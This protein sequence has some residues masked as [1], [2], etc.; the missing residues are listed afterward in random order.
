MAKAYLTTGPALSIRGTA[1]LWDGFGHTGLSGTLLCASD[2]RHVKHLITIVQSSGI[3]KA[4]TM[5]LKTKGECRYG[6]S[7]Y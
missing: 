3:N 4:Y 7:F 6:I 1:P 2:K 5:P